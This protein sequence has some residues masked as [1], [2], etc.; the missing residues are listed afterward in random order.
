ML[1]KPDM[2]ENTEKKENGS[3]TKNPTKYILK[4]DLIFHKKLF[5][6]LIQRYCLL[7]HYNYRY[8]GKE[9]FQAF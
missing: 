6:S 2:M 1:C 3:K 9:I 8:Y 5:E 7:I 4:N